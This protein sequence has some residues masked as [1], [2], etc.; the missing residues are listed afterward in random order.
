IN[1]IAKKIDTSLLSSDEI[2][3]T[4]KLLIFIDESLDEVDLNE[5]LKYKK[6]ELKAK[7]EVFQGYKAKTGEIEDTYN[8]LREIKMKGVIWGYYD[9]NEDRINEYISSKLKDYNIDKNTEF[10]IIN[11]I[12]IAQN[13]TKKQINKISDIYNI[14]LV[15]KAINGNEICVKTPLKYR[16]IHWDLLVELDYISNQF[17]SKGKE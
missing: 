1:T 4:L 2:I 7:N 17:I 5:I 16:D 11:F 9:F 3:N 14:S 8:K 6:G 12:L 10:V 15:K 13:I